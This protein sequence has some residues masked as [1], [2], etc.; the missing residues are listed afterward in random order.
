MRLTR[1]GVMVAAGL[2][3]TAG[4]AHADPFGDAAI[5]ASLE[6][7]AAF[8]VKH[9]G[10]AGDEAC[11]AWL[12]GALRAAG[13]AVA[14]DP[15]DT[16]WFDNGPSAL[17]FA[18]TRIAVAPQAVVARTGDVTGPLRLDGAAG[19][20]RGAIVVVV[21]PL[22]RWS[23]VLAREVAGPI[24]AAA[25]DG[26]A[27]VV[28]V[29][30]GPTAEIIALNAPPGA[31]QPLPVVLLAPKHAEPVV[32]AAKA[33]ARA[34][35]S[36]VGKGGVRRAFNV[37]GTLDRG[38][39]KRVALSTPRSGWTIAAGERGGGVAAWLAL[40]QW[41]ARGLPNNDLTLVCT[42][43]HEY[44]YVGGEHFLHGPRAPKP[45]ETH[46]WVHLGANFAA[47]DWHEFGAGRL[48]PLPSVDPQRVLM[49][50]P[51]LIPVLR[52]SF[53]GAPGLEAPYPSGEG[54]A[55]ELASVLAAGYR[56]AFGVFGAHRLHHVATD[57]LRCVE[58]RHVA[59]AAA[60]M[61]DAVAR[62]AA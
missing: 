29:T 23:T 54:A 11:G 7:F 8:G 34:T 40:A 44:E 22:R 14:R 25:R 2:A 46:L 33:G 3:A 20:G 55:G 61:R 45:A 18:D 17:S 19:D 58:A 1:R 15:F 41:A 60:M 16:P 51:D 31:P 28:L 13:Y 30:S 50:T 26:A 57:D 35:L 56:R 52:D 21:L 9:A 37:I 48:A 43:G 49:G 62:L 4:E 38:K 12:E 47:R 36:I 6:R 24:A 42:S 39:G 53:R 59:V 5:A 10:G 32:A 27:G